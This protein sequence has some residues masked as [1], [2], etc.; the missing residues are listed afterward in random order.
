MQIKD[1]SQDERDDVLDGWGFYVDEFGD[2]RGTHFDGRR[3]ALKSG[4]KQ[5]TALEWAQNDAINGRWVCRSWPRCE[6]NTPELCTAQRR[7]RSTHALYREH[8][9]PIEPTQ[10][11]RR[12]AQRHYERELEKEKAA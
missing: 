2:C 3:T 8:G 7:Q 4:N 12:Q 10:Q 1:L 11:Q 5:A 9:T 6:H